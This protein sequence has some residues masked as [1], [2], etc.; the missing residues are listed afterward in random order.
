MSQT[1]P[2]L[3]HSKQEMGFDMAYISNV[4]DDS[5]SITLEDC[6]HCLRRIAA[7]G[8]SVSTASTDI[9]TYPDCSYHN[10]YDLGISVS[11][12]ASSPESG[13]SK[14]P[15]SSKYAKLDAI[16]FFNP[17]STPL[18]G[19]KVKQ[20]WDGYSP[21]PLPMT[22]RFPSTSLHLPSPKPGETGQII[23]RPK[24]LQIGRHTTGKDFVQCL[25]EPSRKGGGKFDVPLF[26]EWSKVDLESDGGRIASL[27]IM[28]ELR[29]PGAGEKL[30]NEQINKGA[31]GVWDRA[32]NW[33][34]QGFKVFRPE[35]KSS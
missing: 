5:S 11:Y 9:K 7:D 33:E 21:P 34:W 28:V 32:A 17:P 23:A 24:E 2:G 12:L 25:G 26:L 6:I 22:F 10:Y 19:R 27:G 14:S 30:T 4:L 13:P 29:D 31:G 18:P 20:P 1:L 16:D 8:S 3:S 35:L 15:K